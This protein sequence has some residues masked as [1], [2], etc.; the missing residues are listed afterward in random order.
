MSSSHI[1]NVTDGASFENVI[2]KYA[3]H[4]HQPLASSRY[5]YNDEIRFQIQQQDI[6]TLPSE[7]FLL[8]EGKLHR[9]AEDST[10]KFVNNGISFLFDEVRYELNGMEVDKTRN[11]G[12]STLLKGLVSFTRGDQKALMNA[13]WGGTD[14]STHV[15]NDT[16]KEFTVCVPL[17]M[18]LGFAEDYQKIII[19]A[20]THNSKS[21]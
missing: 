15:Y 18:W 11:L 5:T 7:S 8:I 2:T 4:A 13:G 14:F 21:T 20:R 10:S 19:G 9:A 3:F 1:L 17:K 6:Y 12:Y 16:S